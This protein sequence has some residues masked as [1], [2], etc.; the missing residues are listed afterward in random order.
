M[1]GIPSLSF[2]P[3]SNPI[4]TG[5]IKL[6]II[7]CDFQTY[8]MVQ[9]P[10]PAHNVPTNAVSVSPDSRQ[11]VSGSVNKTLPISSA[12]D[13]PGEDPW[14]S[15]PTSDL[16]S[17]AYSPNGRRIVSGSDDATI[18]VCDVDTAK[19]IAVPLDG[20]SR[21]INRIKFSADHSDFVST[22]DE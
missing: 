18:T 11:I 6:S 10:F 2:S 15:T 22:S 19:S 1:H 7:V 16:P 4:A 17:T 9:G 20:H 14:H 13:S 5:S 3:D 12:V 21:Y 8:D